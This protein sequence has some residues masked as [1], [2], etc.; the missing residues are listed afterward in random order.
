MP[1][2]TL[3]FQGEHMTGQTLFQKLRDDF[4][5]VAERAKDVTIN[6]AQIP[7][8]V[9]TIEALAAP[10]TLDDQHHLV[11][12][13]REALFAYILI[14]D[15]INFGSGY[16]PALIEEGVHIGPNG[17]YFTMAQAFKERFEKEPVTLQSARNILVD[18]VNQTFDL[19]KGPAS[20]ELG[21]HFQQ[22]ITNLAGYISTQSNSFEGFVHMMH[23]EAAQCVASLAQVTE[24]QDQATYQGRMIHFLKRA[25][26]TAADLHL[27]AGKLGEDL[28]QD[29]HQLTIFADNAVPHVLRCDGLMQ[30]SPDLADQIERQVNIPFGS[31]QEVEIRACAA[32]VVELMAQQSDLR[33]MDLDHRL[34]HRSKDDDKKAKPTHRTRTLFY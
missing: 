10:D 9:R 14:L 11:T 8:Y 1:Y 3:K 22:A 28:F 15:S 27:G 13:N 34:W 5:F 20:T 18:D 33:V 25:Q 12:D 19:G 2:F 17:F 24:F 7:D 21:Q 31:P 29:I 26:I 6:T 16:K 32:H 30:Y 4:A 23:G